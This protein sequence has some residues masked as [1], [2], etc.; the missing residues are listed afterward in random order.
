MD[1][2]GVGTKLATCA[3]EGGGAL[4][5]VYKLVC[6]GGRPTLKATSDPAKGTLPGEKELYRVQDASG[7]HLFDLITLK[8]EPINC[9]DEVFDPENAGRSQRI[10]GGTELVELRQPVMAEGAL[11][12]ADEEFE[13][14]SRRCRQ[15]LARLPDGSLRLVNPHRYKVSISCGLLRLRQELLVEVTKKCGSL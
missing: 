5:G 12:G 2:Y 6:I 4:G 10:P 3:G 8:D 13:T 9:G 15:Q 7:Q 14:M 1:I 11:L